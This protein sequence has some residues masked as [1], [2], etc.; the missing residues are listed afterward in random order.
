MSPETD[1]F[2]EDS[3]QYLLSNNYKSISIIKYRHI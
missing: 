2:D 1:S 3:D